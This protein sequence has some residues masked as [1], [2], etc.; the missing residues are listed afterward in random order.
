MV[1]GQAPPVGMMETSS[2]GSFSNAKKK[3]TEKVRYV[4]A[5]SGEQQNVKKKVYI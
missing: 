2:E 5:L 1:F 4:N 3:S